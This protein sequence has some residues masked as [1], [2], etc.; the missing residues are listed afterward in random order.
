MEG[1][2]TGD[3]LTPEEARAQ[4]EKYRRDM[5]A[6]FADAELGR[7]VR[8]MLASEHPPEAVEKEVLDFASGLLGA[9]RVTRVWLL[10][11]LLQVDH[12]GSLAT[13]GAMGE[14]GDV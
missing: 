11:E 12:W 13:G 7:R 4:G 9:A 1:K 6:L 10:R 8:E 5:A 14:G 2:K 3:R